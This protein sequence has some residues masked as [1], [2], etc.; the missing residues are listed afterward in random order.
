MEDL[1]HKANELKVAAKAA[2]DQRILE[3]TR[4]HKSRPSYIGWK[5]AFE[6]AID[7]AKARRDMYCVVEGCKLPTNERAF[8]DLQLAGF[9][10]DDCRHRKIYQLEERTMKCLPFIKYNKKV[11]VGKITTVKFRVVEKEWSGRRF[12]NLDYDEKWAP[13][14]E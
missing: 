13:Y 14:H 4:E 10:I 7:E 5:E 2:Y 1:R 8:L 12:A 6:K 11:I 9:C 3:L